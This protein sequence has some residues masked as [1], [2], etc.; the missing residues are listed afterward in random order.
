MKSY[1]LFWERDGV[2][3]AAKGK[4]LSLQ[5]LSGWDRAAFERL[6]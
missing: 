2:L 6:T 3:T 4:A 1:S 5:H